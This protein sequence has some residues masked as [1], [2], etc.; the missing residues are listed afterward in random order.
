V[1]YTDTLE[2]R[3]GLLTPLVALFAVLIYHY[4]RARWRGLAK[5]LG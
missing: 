1:R 4:R 2:V 5:I 3:A